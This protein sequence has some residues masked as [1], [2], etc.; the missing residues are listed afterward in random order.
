L[1]QPKTKIYGGIT[2][3]VS[4]RRNDITANIDVG[5]GVVTAYRKCPI[6]FQITRQRAAGKGL[7]ANNSQ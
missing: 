4:R 6:L 7:N 2:G 5:N 3:N 1:D